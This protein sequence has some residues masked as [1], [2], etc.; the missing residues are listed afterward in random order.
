MLLCGDLNDMSPS[1]DDAAAAQSLPAPSS[2]RGGF[3]T[4]DKADARRLWNL[5]ALMP[6]GRNY[7]R[8]NQGCPE[9]I[10]H[11][12]VW[13]SLVKAVDARSVTAVIAPST[14][15]DLASSNGETEMRPA[16]TIHRWWRRCSCSRSK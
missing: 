4:P 1:S 13:E 3:A 16:R 9:L 12:L 6:S 14:A 10:Y 7:S 15:L 5:E 2:T 8:I 11:I